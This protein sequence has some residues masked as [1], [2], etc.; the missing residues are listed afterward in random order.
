MIRRLAVPF[1]LAACLGWVSPAAAREVTQS[2]AASAP[3][4]QRFSAAQSQ[5][6]VVKE[7]SGPNGELLGAGFF[8]FAISYVP[9]LAVGLTSHLVADE[10]LVIPFAGPWLSLADRPSCSRM[11]ARDCE[12][13][14][15][16]KALIISGGVVQALG[17][18]MMLG[19][20]FSSGEKET[21]SAARTS[22]SVRVAPMT[23]KHELGLGAVG[24]F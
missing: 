10:A 13:E 21:T 20:L 12:A 14:D 17:G 18:L 23:G 4:K 7:S 15:G 9:A 6:D 19:G 3:A 8:V 22:P 16:N 11:S 1:A 24:T 2:A 5:V